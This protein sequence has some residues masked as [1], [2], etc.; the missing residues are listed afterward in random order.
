M[1]HIKNIAGCIGNFIK[2]SKLKYQRKILKYVKHSIDF[3][4]GS[5]SITFSIQDGKLLTLL[6]K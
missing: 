6:M 1:E 5:Y 3:E 4:Y 2:E